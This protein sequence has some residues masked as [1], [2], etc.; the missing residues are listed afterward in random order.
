MGLGD[1]QSKKWPHVV[2]ALGLTMLKAVSAGGAH[3]LS[4]SDDGTVMTM[5]ENDRGQLGH[6][7]DQHFIPVP[8]EIGLPDEI[9][10]ISAGEKH[11]LAVSTS[12]EVWAWGSN[13]C[14]QLGTGIHPQDRTDP[15]RHVEPRVVSSLRGVKIVQ[16]EAGA[17]HS[18][19]LSAEGHVYS[20]GSSA[21][22]ALGHGPEMTQKIEWTP[23]RIRALEGIKIKLVARSSLFSSGVVDERG[24]PFS[25]GN[26][27]YWQLGNGECGH[28]FLPRRIDSLRNCQSLSLGQQHGMAVS[29]GQPWIWG[30]DQ[31]GTLGQGEGISNWQQIPLAVPQTVPLDH[32]K[33]P[34]RVA[35]V[36]CG[37]KS[38]GLLTSDGRIFMWGWNGAY[39]TDP[40]SDSGSG[41]LGQGDEKDRWA[42][43][44][45]QRLMVKGKAYDLR[46]PY[47][48]PWK[49]LSLDLGR[50]HSAAIIEAEVHPKDLM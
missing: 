31:N 50:N 26:G 3:T 15:G 10:S 29:N 33:P 41:V 11:S 49:A 27:L 40:I 38:S 42:P 23:R 7:S 43:N 18:L 35:S 5:G 24:R 46:M 30:T 2:T 32:I 1:Q 25:W 21:F 20:W 48:K 19:A 28:Q 8:L 17:T 22:G 45:V 16:V 39:H 47:I 12:G 9:S 34:T 6:S 14:G 4:L 37:W 13:D 44:Q 36:H